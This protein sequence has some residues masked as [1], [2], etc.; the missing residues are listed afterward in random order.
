MKM[1]KSTLRLS[2][3]L[4]ICMFLT[5][6]PFVLSASAKI[7]PKSNMEGTKLITIEKSDTL[8]DLA[9]KHLNDPFLW[10]ELKKYNNFTNPNLIYPAEKLQLPGKIVLPEST[11]RGVLELSAA[12]GSITKAELDAIKKGLTDQVKKLSKQ[13]EG[14]QSNLDAIQNTTQSNAQAIDRLNESMISQVEASKMQIE[15]VGSSV[16]Q[17]QDELNQIHDSQRQQADDLKDLNATAKS[18]TTGI[19]A[20]KES[21]GALQTGINQL[22][23]D[24][25]KLKN[26]AGEW[27]EPSKSKRT[28]AILA[29]VAGGA[30]WF[31][32]NAI[33]SSD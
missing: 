13:N 30:A 33:G 3:V 5:G 14:L 20:S 22:Q 4:Y 19:S 31:I 32:V 10:K 17:L 2:L 16:G 26:D 15:E 29:V 27:E 23:D 12:D 11:A 24:V 6:A 9:A 8:W 7:T 18:L 1:M 25:G 21:I 28:V